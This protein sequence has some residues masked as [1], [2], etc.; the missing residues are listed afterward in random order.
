MKWKSWHIRHFAYHD[1]LISDNNV[2][3]DTVWE[4]LWIALIQC[5]SKKSLRGLLNQ[6][7]NDWNQSLGGKERYE[8]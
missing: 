8:R 6:R 2:D 3:F 7:G 5:T 1:S 4:W